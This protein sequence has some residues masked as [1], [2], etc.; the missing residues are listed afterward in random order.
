MNNFIQ[1]IVEAFD[2]SGNAESGNTQKRKSLISGMKNWHIE[3]VKNELGDKL[4]NK[5]RPDDTVW[6]MYKDTPL[7]PVNSYDELRRLINNTVGF[8]GDECSLNWI[9]TSNIDDMSHLFS[10]KNFL[11][12][13]NGD[14]SKWNTSNVKNMAAMFASSRFNGDISNWDVSNVEKMDTMFESSYFNGDIS[15]WDVSNVKHMNSMFYSSRAF[16]G[17]L[18]KWDVSNVID[19]NY[20]FTGSSFTGDISNWNIINVQDADKPFRNSKILLKYRPKAPGVISDEEIQ[21]SFDFN[22]VNKASGQKATASTLLLQK[23][24][25]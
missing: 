3:K 7:Y 4:M 1:K 9:D 18:S 25:F 12:T 10:T 8:F 23:K 6:N 21:E 13:F 17:D 20:M 24:N 15:N 19:M 14:I 16:N 11:H 5:E 2:F 22:N